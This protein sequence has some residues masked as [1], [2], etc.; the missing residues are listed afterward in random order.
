MSARYFGFIGHF[1]KF[2]SDISA[3]SKKRAALAR[4]IFADSW[5]EPGARHTLLPH[6]KSFTAL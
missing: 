4:G 3:D 5:P 2:L 1:L 6:F